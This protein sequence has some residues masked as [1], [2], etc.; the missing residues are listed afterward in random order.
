M[1]TL[2]DYWQLIAR[3]FEIVLGPAQRMKKG[4]CSRFRFGLLGEGRWRRLVGLVEAIRSCVLWKVGGDERNYPPSYLAFFFRLRTVIYSHYLGPVAAMP[5][6]AFY[7]VP[8]VLEGGSY[9]VVVAAVVV[10]AA[11]EFVGKE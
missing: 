8:G 3:N 9:W 7:G 5:Q 10:A 6:R 4:G 11:V 1:E 2:G